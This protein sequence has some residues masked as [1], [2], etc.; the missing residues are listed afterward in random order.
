MWVCA[1]RG[2]FCECRETKVA[3]YIKRGCTDDLVK[4]IYMENVRVNVLSYWNMLKDVERRKLISLKLVP[5]DISP[6][7]LD[8]I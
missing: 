6:L 1:W 2:Y 5:S 7:V 8:E 3:K 4:E